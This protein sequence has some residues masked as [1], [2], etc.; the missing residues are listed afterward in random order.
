[1]KFSG[2]LNKVSHALS[3]NILS[4]V[5]SILTTLLVPKM[6]GVEGFGYFQL[7]L[8]Y[9]SYVGLLHFGWNDG[10][11]LRLGGLEYANLPR[12]STFSQ[13][14]VLV[15]QQL[16]VAIS[17]TLIAVTLIEDRSMS[18][19]LSMTG[20]CIL[21]SGP[22]YMLLFILQATARIKEYARIVVIQRL[23]FGLLIVLMSFTPIASFDLLIYTDL[24]ARTVALLIALYY[25]REV[26]VLS[27]RKFVWPGREII[28]NLSGG[29]PLM[30]SAMAGSLIIGVVRLGIS[31]NWSVTVFGKVS[32]ALS[33]SSIVLTAIVA[34]GQVLFPLLRRT[35]SSRL[36]RIFS[37][38]RAILSLFTLPS[39]FLYFLL[40]PFI[41]YWLPE[42]ID[43]AVYLGI[44]FP[45]FIYQVRTS[46][47]LEPYLKTMRMEKALLCVNAG[48]L[49][50]SVLV[51]WVC[52]YAV[53]S[54]TATLAS[55]VILVA[56]RAFALEFFVSKAMDVGFIFE[57]LLEGIVVVVFLVGVIFLEGIWPLV[58]LA[59][60]LFAWVLFNR[61]SIGST[62]QF[63][64]S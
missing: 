12:K 54:L 49:V 51:T 18:L 52:V 46:I 4:L 62:I 58:A 41:S 60:V 15:V 33:L 57:A 45:L 17:V 24:A 53:G 38:G 7:Y 44:I 1:M 43:S 34:V 27:L 2:F 10:V 30:L 35:S 26:A 28:A 40:V 63:L 31:D 64:R 37:S 29:F 6:V 50:L 8:F 32:L 3:A 39:L 59:S 16:L 13:F 11:L 56:I 9:S 25:C 14:T 19:I 48:I 55:M 20:V 21:I 5:I 61:N 22:M 47:L 23:L 36:P 42:Y